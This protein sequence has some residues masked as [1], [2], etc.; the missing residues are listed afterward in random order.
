MALDNIVMDNDDNSYHN[1]MD[2]Y[3]HNDYDKIRL[4]L[5]YFRGLHSLP[6]NR[7]NFP[8]K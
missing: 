5:C 3:D 7:G 2:V 1:D 6:S 4:C 8:R